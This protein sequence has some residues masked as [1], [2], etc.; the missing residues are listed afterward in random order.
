MIK[1][2]QIIFISIS[3]TEMAITIAIILLISAILIPIS[4]AMITRAVYAKDLA[5]ARSLFTCYSM[6]CATGYPCSSVTNAR[7]LPK[8]VEELFGQLPEGDVYSVSITNG[9]TE[10][11][12]YNSTSYSI[13]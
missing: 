3:L 7:H 1:E 5:N 12:K 10:S 13:N 2:R 9:T 11:V 4:S 8:E 6:L